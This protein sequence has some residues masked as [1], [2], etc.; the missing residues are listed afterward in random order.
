MKN[1]KNNENKIKNIKYKLKDWYNKVTHVQHYHLGNTL[2]EPHGMKAERCRKK[3]CK[4][5]VKLQ[6]PFI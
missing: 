3:D 5:P 2:F 1:N 4:K 6:S